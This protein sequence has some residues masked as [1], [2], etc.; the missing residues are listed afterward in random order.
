MNEK[1]SAMRSSR[2]RLP[3]VLQIMCH[4]LRSRDLP[5]R[6]IP[7]HFRDTLSRFGQPIAPAT[8]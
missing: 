5:R 2:Q 4:S 6:E 7:D 3:V 8:G 1:I